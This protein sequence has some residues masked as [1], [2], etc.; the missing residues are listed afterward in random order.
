VVR[1]RVADAAGKMVTHGYLEAADEYLV[2]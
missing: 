1:E 2:G